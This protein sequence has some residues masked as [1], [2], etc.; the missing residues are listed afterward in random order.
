MGFLNNDNKWD[1]LQNAQSVIIPS[2][3]YEV[4][5]IVLIE[6]MAAGI[7]VVVSNNGNLSCIVEPDKNAFLFD[8]QDK[9]DLKRKLLQI[10]ENERLKNEM[11][12]CGKE[13]FERRYSQ[14][15]FYNE[16]KEIYQKVI[17]KNLSQEIKK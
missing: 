12:K 1:I 11:G 16:L 7:P 2:L 17:E 6:S 9:E 8:P 13:I 10:W 3:C 14:K 15:V 5:P 4:F